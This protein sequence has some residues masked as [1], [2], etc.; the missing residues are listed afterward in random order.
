MAFT[1]EDVAAYEQGAAAA[2]AP[3]AASAAA[4][5]EAAAAPVSK[6]TEGATAAPAVVDDAT[7]APASGD[8]GE[9]LP[10][11][12]GDD[13]S[14]A[15]TADSATAPAATDGEAVDEVNVPRGRARERI[16]ELVAE[17][18]ALRKYGEHLLARLEDVSKRT[19]SGADSTQPAAAPEAAVS[20]E[21]APTLE[22]FDYDPDAFQKAQAQWLDK[23]VDR[24]VAAALAQREVAQDVAKVT[25]AF[26]TRIS[27][28][29][30]AHADFDTVVANPDLPKLAPSTANLV[31]RSKFGPQ[32]IYHL[33]K[34][35]DVATRISRLT[36][37]LQ[38]EAVGRLTAKFDT[39]DTAPSASQPPARR[40][41]SKAPPPPTPVQGSTSPEKQPHEMSMA[42]FVAKERA[43]RLARREASIKMRKA[44]R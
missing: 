23:Q 27:D 34:N 10:S 11:D 3:A 5:T 15:A 29:K 36:P 35:P 32:L 6:A 38:H 42:E 40:T 19:P 7:G 18:N 25:E 2:A 28:F 44:M 17:R 22:Q 24:R 21:S 31:V 14:S 43:E 26:Q 1:R 37:E 41:V 33:A 9:A 12:T 20:P 16:E 4:P 13:G 39:E 30:K 8:P